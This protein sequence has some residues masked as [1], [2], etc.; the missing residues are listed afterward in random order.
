M[1]GISGISSYM[2]SSWTQA[3]TS[4]QG[5]RGKE[6][7]FRKIDTD[8]SGTVSKTELEA[9]TTKMS[10]KTGTTVSTTDAITTYDKDGDGEL[11]GTELRG[12]LDA[13]R[14]SQPPMGMMGMG[15]MGMMSMGMPPGPS[16]EQK[17]SEADA[18][19][20]GGLSATELDT[21]VSDISKATG[22]EIDTTDAITAY[23]SDGDGELSSDE[24][25]SFLDASGVTPPPPPPMMGMNGSDS[26]DS[27]ISSVSD[28]AITGYDSD[29]DGKLSGTELKSF[30]TA[31]IPKLASDY[32][33]RALAAYAGTSGSETSSSM[34]IDA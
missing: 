4:H 34:S 8:A 27:L 12:F 9:F 3:M 19:S 11:S 33:M 17:F 7:L 24:V 10:Q 29:G 23:D 26:I 2:N 18:D 16:P 14:P 25:Q 30:L 28:D 32:V 31:N 22:A 15:G 5:N 13:N 21:L 6:D 1:S 20:S